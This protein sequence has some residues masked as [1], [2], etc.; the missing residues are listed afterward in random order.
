MRKSN[1]MALLNNDQKNLK[2]DKL[3]VN[4]DEKNILLQVKI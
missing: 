2:I 4:E 3:T 1:K